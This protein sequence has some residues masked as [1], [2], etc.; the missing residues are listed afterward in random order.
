[1]CLASKMDQKYF[2]FDV[3]TLFIETKLICLSGNIF[4]DDLNFLHN[5]LIYFPYLHLKLA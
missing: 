2:L 3:I 5:Y 1:M 4:W